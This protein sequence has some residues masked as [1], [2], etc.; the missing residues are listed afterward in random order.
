[1]SS[2]TNDAKASEIKTPKRVTNISAKEA[3]K[4]TVH[5]LCD[6][7]VMTMAVNWVLSPSSAKNTI[8]NVVKKSFQSIERFLLESYFYIYR[9]KYISSKI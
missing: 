6:L 4:N 1:M 9:K 5:I 2:G 3:D 8:Q 7:A